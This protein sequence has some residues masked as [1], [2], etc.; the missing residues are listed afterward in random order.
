MN[1]RVYNES[2]DYSTVE[3]WWNLHGIAPMPP[4][5]LRTIGYVSY[6][7]DLDI[8]AA[9]LH[10]DHVSTVS[11][12]NLFISN[13]DASPKQVH[14]AHMDIVECFQNFAESEGFSVIMAF[15]HKDSLKKVAMRSGFNINHSNV[16]EMYKV[17][18]PVA[19]EELCHQ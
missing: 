12:M 2:E 18:N 14:K 9:W 15:Y 19:K 1:I 17:L 5:I 8:A 3:N 10:M 6:K 11:W 7:D 13:P 16:C 4:H